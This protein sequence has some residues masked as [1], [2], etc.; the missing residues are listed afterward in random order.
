MNFRILSVATVGD[1]ALYW[2]HTDHF[3]S[4]L[5]YTRLQQRQLCYAQIILDYKGFVYF[6]RVLKV[7]EDF[8]LFITL[9]LLDLDIFQEN[10]KPIEFQKLN[11]DKLN[12]VEEYVKHSIK[13]VSDQQYANQ[14]KNLLEIKQ[15]NE[16]INS[17]TNFLNQEFSQKFEEFSLEIQPFLKQINFL[18]CIQ[19]KQKFDLLKNCQDQ[20]LQDIMKTYKKGLFY[21][22]QNMFGTQ[23]YKGSKDF[24]FS[25]KGNGEYIIA[26]KNSN[27]WNCCISSLD[28]KKDL[29][30]IFRIQL[31][32]IDE[33]DEFIFGLMRN[34]ISQNRAGWDDQL[35][36]KLKNESQY[37]IK[38]QG[39]YGIHNNLK[40]IGEFKLS[41]E[42]IIELR[43]SLKDK[44]LQV[45]DYPN[46][47]YKLGLEDKQL[48]KL[49]QYD[50]LRFYVG[51][52][53]SSIQICLKDAKIVNRF[54]D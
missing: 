43:I 13:L 42:N 48:P 41:T 10:K 22:N 20:I 23:Y 14:T 39:R 52:L 19:D 21:Y 24:I 46:Y 5:N 44:L 50:D 7:I 37:L 47:Q 27:N 6:C 29:K 12:L 36:C 4:C 35:S 2:V 1:I 38:G 51:F 15:I 34:S 18:N 45:T 11:E 54:K 32:I 40:G 53:S 31:E 25:K 28:L 33:Q 16:I 3:D 9:T 26:K 17:K 30:Y 8:H 49:E